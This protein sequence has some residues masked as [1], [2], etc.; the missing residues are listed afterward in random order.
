MSWWLQN[1]RGK[2]IGT[3]LAPP[4]VAAVIVYGYEWGASAA[5][6]FP[7]EYIKV[8]YSPLL[9]LPFYLLIAAVIFVIPI[10]GMLPDSFL[11]IWPYLRTRVPRLILATL[12][13]FAAVALFAPD[14]NSRALLIGWLI[15]AIFWLALNAFYVLRWFRSSVARRPKFWKI[16]SAL[17]LLWFF[18]PRT[19]GR[20]PSEDLLSAVP[21][22][23]LILIAVVYYSFAVSYAQGYQ[24]AKKQV[25]FAVIRSSPQEIVLRRYGDEVVTA[26]FDP[27]TRAVYSDFTERHLDSEN[28]PTLV[29]EAV[30]P[31]KPPV[32]DPCCV[33]RR[34]SRQRA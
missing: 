25:V 15:S 2:W 24:T 33:P 8:E 31:I 7:P 20:W 17:H 9:Q 5:L 19:R 3:L 11:R 30:G 13:V 10:I 23:Y 21:G 4:L 16:A 18:K 6:G 34:R 32:W 1:L 26:R 22:R 12:S 29:E 27:R 28:P 14:M